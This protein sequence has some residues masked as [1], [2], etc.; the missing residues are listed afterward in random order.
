MENELRIPTEQAVNDLI[1]LNKQIEETAT[2]VELLIK[3]MSEYSNVL[4]K[5]VG[6]VKELRLAESE[7]KALEEELLLKRKQLIEQETK[8]QQEQKKLTKEYWD[9]TLAQKEKIAQAKREAEASNET[10]QARKREKEAIEKQKQEQ[11]ELNTAHTQALKINKELNNEINKAHGEALKMNKAFDQ[12][13]KGTNEW[14]IALGSFQFKFN[15]LGNLIGN[16]VGNTISS[17]LGGIKET[18]GQIVQ[19]TIKL[20]SL[21]T[22]YKAIFENNDDYIESLRQ[23]NIMAENNGTSILKLKEQYISFAAASKGTAMQGKASFDVF[24]SITK[25]LTILGKTGEQSDR[26]LLALTQMMSKGTIQAEELKTQMGDSLPGAINIMAKAVGTNVEGLM[27]MMKAGEVISSD[28]LPKFAIELEKA[29]GADTIERIETLPAKI[30]RSETAFTN[31]VDS[32]KA[33]GMIGWWYDLKTAIWEALSFGENGI[34]KEVAGTLTAISK[35]QIDLNNLNIPLERRKNIYAEMQAQYPAYLGSLDLEKDGLQKINNALNDVTSGM[36]VKLGLSREQEKVDKKQKEYSE[37]V[38]D[39]AKEEV[40]A[41]ELLIRSKEYISKLGVDYT[42]VINT[43][44]SALGQLQDAFKYINEEAPKN[45]NFKMF[46]ERAG[47]VNELVTAQMDLKNAYKDTRISLEEWQHA[48][49]NL[50]KI[51]K[52][53]TDGINGQ[54][55]AKLK[56]N[57]ETNKQLRNKQLTLD[58]TNAEIGKLNQLIEKNKKYGDIVKALNDYKTKLEA[59]KSSLVNS[60]QYDPMKQE[61]KSTNDLI[62]AINKYI[63]TL[64]ERKDAEKESKSEKDNAKKE[65]DDYMKLSNAKYEYDLALA[66]K[67]SLYIDNVESKALVKRLDDAKKYVAEKQKLGVY[68]EA[69]AIEMINTLNEKEKQLYN[70]KLWYGNVELER[71]KIYS[72]VRN[73]QVIKEQKEQEKLQQQK[74]R[75]YERERQNEIARLQLQAERT[76][77]EG[78][79]T[80]LINGRRMAT[81]EAIK[82]EEDETSQQIFA[83]R[84]VGKST[85]ALEKHMIAL[86]KLKTS[87][88]SATSISA[89]FAQVTLQTYDALTSVIEAYYDRQ[90]KMIEISEKRQ[91]ASAKR[92]MKEQIAAGKS[93]TE[94]QAEYDLK[95]AKIQS[96]IAYEKDMAAWKRAKREKNEAMVRINIANSEAVMKTAAEDGWYA[97]IGVAAMGTAALIVAGS[98]PLPDKP[99]KEDYYWKGTLDHKGGAAVVNDRG[100]GRELVIEPS[101]K[102]YIPQGENVKLPNLPKHSMVIPANIT[103]ELIDASSSGGTQIDLTKV[104]S[105]LGDINNKKSVTL[106][107]DSRKIGLFVAESER[108]VKKIN[109]LTGKR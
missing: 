11:K 87:L 61:V 69:E 5:N 72:D 81:I 4:N 76:N 102:S 89:E 10:L 78:T 84:A 13:K 66:E 59:D 48:E 33:S 46:D 42:K 58:A 62:T 37:S 26:V 82:A 106:G 80:S 101:G 67:T 91:I 53:M 34:T 18:V 98:Q 21:N 57:E 88:K 12:A 71:L 19:E 104:E 55:Y 2:K 22:T 99:N 79:I 95:L 24:N 52:Q 77:K 92:K 74:D 96:D 100:L 105:L 70:N 28:I 29:Y 75:D 73:D 25:S 51:T 85:E 41:N 107:V 63:S 38:A 3:N 54:A 40:K 9:Y 108:V 47:L 109:R 65:A 31:F 14:G 27:K 94:A 15:M 50:D 6:S 30:G 1:A 23:L 44:K 86:D 7:I 8:A 16:F 36:I 49:T 56:D 35:A 17:F 45:K 60:G 93:S 97:A 43:Q 20:N 103:K 32:M 39:A 68:S 83:Y 90:D 64:K